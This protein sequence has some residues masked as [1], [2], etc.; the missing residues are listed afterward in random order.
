MK[1]LNKN[2]LAFIL[3]IKVEDARAMMCRAWEKDNDLPAKSFWNKKNKII[4]D[5]PPAMDILM[6][7]KVLNLPTLLQSADDI[8]KN[9]LTRAAT[10][11]WILCD[12]P[13]KEIRLQEEKGKRPTIQIPP[14]LRSM[15]PQNTIEQIRTIWTERFSFP[16]E[17]GMPTVTIK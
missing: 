8:E 2:Q 1:Y 13:E 15:L 9:Y 14:A 6:L 12:F 16:D 17:N 3:D 4:D 7:S 11:K 5:Y 10:K